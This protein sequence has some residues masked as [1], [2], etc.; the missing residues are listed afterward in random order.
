MK[1]VAVS[2]QFIA[3]GRRQIR[4]QIYQDVDPT[5]GPAI[6]DLANSNRN[7]DEALAVGAL[8]DEGIFDDFL[9]QRADGLMESEFLRKWYPDWDDA[10]HSGRA[11][12]LKVDD[13]RLQSRQ[14]DHALATTIEARLLVGIFKYA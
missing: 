3:Q 5:I 11:V 10:S 14:G 4:S 12:V 1:A 8:D 2:L 13:L 6:A 7:L 9:F